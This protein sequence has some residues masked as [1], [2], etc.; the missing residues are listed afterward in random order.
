MSGSPF[1]NSIVLAVAVVL[2]SAHAG[3]LPSSDSPFNQR[4]PNC[5]TNAPE[6]IAK[7]SAA[8]AIACPLVKDEAGFL[9]E[10]AA[11]HLM[12]GVDHIRFY[13]DA[14]KSGSFDELAPWLATGQVEVVAANIPPNLNFTSVM[15]YKNMLEADCKSYAFER[16]YDLL[17]SLDLDEYLVPT[18]PRMAAIDELWAAMETI[19]LYEIKLSKFNFNSAPHILEPVNLLTIEAYQSRM[20][21]ASQMTFFKS[22]APK[23]ALRLSGPIYNKA[24]ENYTAVLNYVR[25]CNFH[26]CPRNFEANFS[27]AMVRS[28][29]IGN[30]KHWGGASVPSI[31]HYSRSLEK[32]GA[33][34]ET[35]RTAGGIVGQT[36]NLELFLDRSVGW[37]LDNRAA[38]HYGCQVR[39]IISNMTNQTTYF[40]P[41]DNWYRNKEFG[42]SGGGGKQQSQI[43]QKKLKNNNNNNNRKNRN[44]GEGTMRASNMSK[45]WGHAPYHYVGEDWP[46]STAQ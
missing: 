25:Q 38:V 41:G 34:T 15:K 31:Y 22:V 12:H 7:Q 18:Q 26:G 13:D 20:P 10:W 33:K 21:K 36:Y 39:S 42:L 44:N 23:V 4:L 9:S 11:Y 45:I 28:Q 27:E 6:P 43:G 29:F 19:G 17:V 37:L 40:R 24:F 8:R 14:S 16:G 5:K 2:M 32:Y 46:F 3:S 35:W 1:V 30:G